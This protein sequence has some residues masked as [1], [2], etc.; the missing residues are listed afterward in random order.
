MNRG[1]DKNGQYI[2][3]K[4]IIELNMGQFCYVVL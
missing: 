1:D 3:L 2:M 4:N